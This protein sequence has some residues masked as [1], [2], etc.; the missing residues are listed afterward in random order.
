MASPTS[1]RPIPFAI[2]DTAVDVDPSNPLRLIT[3][4]V[5]VNN[6]ND[7][8]LEQLAQ[9]GNGWYRYLN[10][11]SEGRRLFR[12][13]SW[14]P[15]SV[16]FADQTRA[17]VRW[18]L[19]FVKRWRMIGYE[20]RVTSDDSF[21]TAQKNFAEI[22]SSTATTVFFEFEPKSPP[23]QD[24]QFSTLGNVELR[25]VSPDSGD[26]VYQIAGIKPRQSEHDDFSMFGAIVALASDRYSD[27]CDTQSDTVYSATHIPHRI[28][29]KDIGTTQSRIPTRSKISI[30]CWTNW[31][32]ARNL[33]YP[34]ATVVDFG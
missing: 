30:L 15:L 21:A 18:N 28:Y 25:W 19:H 13:E 8:L 22:P 6:Y 29:S 1:T 11:P 33:R 20:N 9:N 32:R 23:T 31:H 12:R 27:V 2:L 3:I 7:V 34:P 16:P 26:D 14:V 5:G 10:E 17:Q 24:P 4:G